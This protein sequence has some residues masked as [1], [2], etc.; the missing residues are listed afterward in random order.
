[1]RHVEVGMVAWDAILL[2][3]GYAALYGL[4]ASRPRPDLRLLPLAFL[5]GWALLGVVLSIGLVAGL[6]PSVPHVVL[7]A[8]AICAVSAVAGRRVA[9][10]P[11][12]A[13]W[14]GDRLARAVSGALGR[15]PSTFRLTLAAGAILLAALIAAW[16][17]SSFHPG[18]AVYAALGAAVVAAA[19]APARARSLAVSHR[20]R[21]LP[22]VFVLGSSIVLATAAVTALIVAIKGDWPSEWDSWG[23]W[24]P[25][26]ETIYYWHGLDTGVGGWGAVS[27]PE[28]PPLLAVMYAGSW[29]FAGGFHPS[30]IPMQQTLLAIGF[31]GGVL[32][33][34]GRLVPHWIALPFVASLAA[35][36]GFWSRTQ[37][38]MADPDLGYLCS[39]AALVALLWLATGRRQWLAFGVLFTAAATYVKAEGLIFSALIVLGAVAGRRRPGLAGLSLLLGPALVLPWRLWLRAHDLPTAS[40]DYHL[41][42]LLHPAFLV[43]RL[44]RL[45]TALHWLL[46]S[47]FRTSQWQVLLP[48]ALAAA[49]FASRRAP[50][51]AAVTVAWLVLGF[52][53]L[54]TIYWIGIPGL[55]YYLSTSAD[56]VSSTLVILAATIAPALVGLAIGRRPADSP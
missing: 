7:A 23:F 24:V 52:A 42:E 29:H 2:A 3:V 21:I 44:H 15:R 50:V 22:A 32:V 6:D 8:A 33:L 18:G 10:D 54:G 48:L 51:A 12:L 14:P 28:Y 35:A 49:A 4:G 25:K 46:H 43:H 20:R 1:M 26:G 19:A 11:L 38:L 45:T 47:V 5:T 40:T 13:P 36:P 16:L 53:G 56:R 27:H 17:S 30:V 41:S 34:L 37:T 9:R 55:G 31:I 39:A